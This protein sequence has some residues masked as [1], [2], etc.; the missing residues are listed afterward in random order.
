VV[1][2]KSN[3]HIINKENF[4]SNSCY[5]LVERLIKYVIIILILASYEILNILQLSLLLNDKLQDVYVYH[6]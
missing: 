6:F 3:F 2:S 1:S 4:I 5:Y